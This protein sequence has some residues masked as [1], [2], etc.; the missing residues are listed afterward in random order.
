MRGERTVRTVDAT[1][2][3]GPAGAGKTTVG[4]ALASALGWQFYDAD[5][6]HPPANVERMRHGIALTDLERHPWLTELQSLLARSIR[7]QQPVVLAC[8]A[9][10]ESY[11]A[12]LMPA[13]ATP[14]AVRFLYLRATPSVLHDRLTERIGHFAPAALLESQMATLEEPAPDEAL[15]VD[16]SLAPRAIVVAVRQ[17]WDV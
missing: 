4:Q 15:I 12:A 2:V 11:R 8:S 1:V 7:D 10:R 3:M 13:N 16:A 17:A 9:L 6:F 14:G 5:D